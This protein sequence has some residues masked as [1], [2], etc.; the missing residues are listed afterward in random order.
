MSVPKKSVDGQSLARAKALYES[1][2]IYSIEIGTVRGLCAIHEYLFKGLLYDFAGKIR[3]LN[4]SKGGF[5][6]ANCL[7]LDAI[8]PIIERMPMGNFDEIVEK[9][10]EMNV[11]HPFLEG[12]GRAMRI[13]F[14]GMLREY[15]GRVVDWRQVD[16]ATYLQAME[17]SPV[18]S[19]E[20]RYLLSGALTE[21][22]EDREVIF[23][24]LE[25]SYY[26]E[27]YQAGDEK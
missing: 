11:A 1:G 10:V 5:R 23:K 4:I 15:I 14:D 2:V 24:G 26:Y 9:Y 6:F 16:K 19:L 3:A 7:Y 17:R 22:V 25:Q 21:R 20:L 8:L 13:W 12:N 18:N 27:G